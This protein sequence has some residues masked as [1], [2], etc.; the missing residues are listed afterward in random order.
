MYRKKGNRCNKIAVTYIIL[1]MTS[2]EVIVN[3]K[4]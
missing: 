2:E 1:E 3:V 4:I